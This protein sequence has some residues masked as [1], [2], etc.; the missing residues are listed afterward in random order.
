MTSRLIRLIMTDTQ[1]KEATVSRTEATTK[2]RAAKEEPAI[3]ADID[4][5]DVK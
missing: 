4:A 1:I 2:E 3:L 5:E